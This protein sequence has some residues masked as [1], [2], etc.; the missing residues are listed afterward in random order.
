MHNLVVGTP[1]EMH[2]M[3]ANNISYMNISLKVGHA[4]KGG[5]S[6]EVVYSRQFSS[7]LVIYPME[8]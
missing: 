1:C 5:E 2:L 3:Q 4:N 7:T 8:P 6:F